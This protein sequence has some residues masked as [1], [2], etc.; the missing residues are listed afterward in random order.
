MESHYINGGCHKH[1]QQ[2]T[3]SKSILC[4]GVNFCG[5]ILLAELIFIQANDSLSFLPHRLTQMPFA[6]YVLPTLMLDLV[7]NDVYF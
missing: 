5:L 3:R 6:L 7:V 1:M 4:T 2:G